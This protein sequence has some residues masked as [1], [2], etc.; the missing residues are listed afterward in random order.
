MLI[1]FVC[2]LGRPMSYILYEPVDYD[3]M[4]V[5]VT[6]QLKVALPLGKLEYS[7]T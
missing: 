4:T 2:R 7:I 3:P 5:T 6:S 1:C